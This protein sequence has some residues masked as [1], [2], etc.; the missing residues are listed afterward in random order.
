MRNLVIHPQDPT[1]I[2][3]KPIYE[4]IEDKT[5][6]EKD[7]CPDNIKNLIEQSDR[8]M[9]MGHGSPHGLFSINLFSVWDRLDF[10]AISDKHADLL[11]NKA[12]SIYIWCHAN[13]FVDFHNLLGF[14][15]GMFISEVAEACF[16]G[17]QNV[18]Q[19]MVDE[20]NKVFSETVGEHINLSK[21][22]LYEKVIKTYGELAKS[23]PVALYNLERLCVR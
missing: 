20:S 1:T 19:E 11:R 18:K 10:F 17:L 22:D 4:K 2:F 8:V 3:L 9:A 16:C 6:I 14:Y 15:S 21:E 13:Q 12:Q 7:T 5:V 23:N